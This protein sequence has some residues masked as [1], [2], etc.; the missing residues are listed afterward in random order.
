LRYMC[1]CKNFKFIIIDDPSS[2]NVRQELMTIIKSYILEVGI[3][4]F[5]CTRTDD[6]FWSID[7]V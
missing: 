5:F 3:H 4:R 7:V 1:H 6:V 2:I